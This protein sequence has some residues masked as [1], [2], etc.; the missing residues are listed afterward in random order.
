MAKLKKAF[1]R[2]IS[3]LKAEA[4]A[5]NPG[6]SDVDLANAINDLARKQG[7]DYTIT[8]DRVRPTAKTPTRKRATAPT[9]AA[10]PAPAHSN[11]APTPRKAE[12]QLV[13]D[14][15]SFVQLVGKDAAR[16]LLTDMVD[17]L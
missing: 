8:P 12:G 10:A 14:L 9:K 13:A 17:R 2:Q 6:A 7:F 3:N 16:S 4:L 5:A 11:S 1:G 15:R